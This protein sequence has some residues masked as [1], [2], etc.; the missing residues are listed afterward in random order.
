MNYKLKESKNLEQ[1]L[2]ESFEKTIRNLQREGLFEN[3]KSFDLD[4]NGKG[5]N[6]KLN[7]SRPGNRNVAHRY[8]SF[9]K[10]SNL[11]ENESKTPLTDMILNLMSQEGWLYDEDW[12]YCRFDSAKF[13]DEV[14]ENT[15][16]DYD[17]VKDYCWDLVPDDLEIHDKIIELGSE[18]YL[19]KKY[20][21]L[22]NLQKTL[23]SDG[24]AEDVCEDLSSTF[25]L[26]DYAYEA[27]AD[28]VDT[29]T[30]YIESRNHGYDEDD[31]DDEYSDED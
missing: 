26:S 3:V 20:G 25:D 28:A 6:I 21:T 5:I 27:W 15:G 16:L 11:K 14:S 18:N 2:A 8:E 4:F 1:K 23:D 24:G 17:D 29:A 12:P 10:H 31:D 30:S 7:E 22:E 19:L 9:K 13:Y